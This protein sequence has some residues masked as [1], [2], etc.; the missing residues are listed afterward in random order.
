MWFQIH[1]DYIP[2]VMVIFLIPRLPVQK[3]I[4]CMSLVSLLMV[5]PTR[6]YRGHLRQSGSGAPRPG[7]QSGAFGMAMEF[8]RPV[9]QGSARLSADR[10]AFHIVKVR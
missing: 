10:Y 2:T 1:A 6:G 4:V 9:Q 8:Q 5:R 3:E 7:P